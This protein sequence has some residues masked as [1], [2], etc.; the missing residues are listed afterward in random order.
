[1][2]SSRTQ[3]CGNLFKVIPYI[4]WTNTHIEILV[5]TFIILNQQLRIHTEDQNMLHAK[6]LKE[7][8]QLIQ[9][10][11]RAAGLKAILIQKWMK[12]GVYMNLAFVLY[13]A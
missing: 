11:G 10:Q 4:Y 12:K 1:M 2:H 5:L 9:I 3:L 13:F 8:I 6:P 7:V